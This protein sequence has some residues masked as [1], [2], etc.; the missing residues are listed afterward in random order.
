MTGKFRFSK[1]NGDVNKHDLILIKFNK[2]IILKYNDVRKFGYFTVLSN[3][4]LY[5]FKN[6][7]KE[8]FL[9]KIL[10]AFCGQ[11]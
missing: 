3:L 8:P 2:G 4:N 5:K 6:L 1:Y 9:L 7:G 10:Q 11:Y